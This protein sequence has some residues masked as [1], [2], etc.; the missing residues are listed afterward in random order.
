MIKGL[1]TISGAILLFALSC[2]KDNEKLNQLP[3]Q[4]ITK[5][6][7]LDDAQAVLDYTPVMQVTPALGEL[8]ADDFYLSLDTAG[9]IQKPVEMNAYFWQP[10]IFQGQTQIADWNTP[11]KQILH[12]NT[13]L[14]ALPTITD[15]SDLIKRN[16][17]KGAALF[18]RA[19]AH[20]QVALLFSSLPNATPSTL[21]IP[22]RL[23]TDPNIPSKRA[24]VADTYTQIL[25][26]LSAAG[27]LLPASTDRKRL[28]RPAKPAAFALMAR[29]YLIMG[30]YSKAESYADSCLRYYST[31]TDYNNFS[32]TID[33]PFSIHNEEVI[34]TSTILSTTIFEKK[35]E[36]ADSTL[37]RSYHPND[38][39]KTIFFRLDPITNLPKQQHSY[40]GKA[41]L[42]SGIATDE[43]YLIR[44]EA[45]AKNNQ[46][47]AAMN[48]LNTLLEKRWK[49]TASFVPYT[50]SSAEDAIQQIRAERRKELVFRG[51]RWVDVRR[52]NR[53]HPADTLIRITKTDVYKL[54]PNDL[55]TVLLLPPD[56]IQLSSMPQNER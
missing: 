34:F 41:S 39:R 20:L 3:D 10:D 11:Y 36:F 30:D 54:Y 31:L 43:V 53:E 52:Y 37:Y 44:A 40:T 19:H 16:N 14:E 45:R 51:L 8:S 32:N 26:D 12:A 46:T 23:S 27:Q 4:S 17:I 13:V 50:A 15:S 47:Q 5:V 33:N 28:N 7:S 42:F 35:Y 56:V 24:T 21:G 18:F 38:L 1:C 2:K 48:D 49:P 9:I 22:L 25:D 55:K 6:R 29:V